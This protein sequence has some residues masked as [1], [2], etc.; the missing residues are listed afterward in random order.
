MFGSGLFDFSDQL[1]IILD[2][3]IRNNV[4][5]PIM[6]VMLCLAILR[7]HVMMILFGPSSFNLDRT[8]D[9]QIGIRTR[10]II[11]N[12]SRISP[13]SY[14]SRKAYLIDSKTGLLTKKSVKATDLLA[15]MNSNPMM[16][17]SNMGN[18]MKGQF[19]GLINQMYMIF[20]YSSIDH[21]FQGFVA[22]KLP[23]SVTKGFKAMF[24]AGIDLPNLELSFISSS[25]WFLLNF[26]G[27]NGVNEI[28]LTPAP[29]R[30]VTE[31][32]HSQI[33]CTQQQ[34]ADTTAIF[35]SLKDSLAIH[36]PNWDAKNSLQRMYNKIEKGDGKNERKVVA[37]SHKTN[38]PKK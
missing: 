19:A 2:V 31:A 20:M 37:E 21:Y 1:T 34:M 9:D 36:E 3:E 27:M 13:A 25:S 5:L 35:T 32:V 7:T 33:M 29:N 14:L 38:K 4:L 12:G 17:P 16:D 23:F 15:T 30:N 10:R 11:A 24:H 8:Y 28:I 22:A 26:T 18:L 6:F